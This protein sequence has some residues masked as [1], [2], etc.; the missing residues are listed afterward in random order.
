MPDS[1]RAG[2][3]FMFGTL[4]EFLAVEFGRVGVPPLPVTE[5]AEPTLAPHGTRGPAFPVVVVLGALMGAMIVLWPTGLPLGTVGAVG[6]AI[7]PLF[8]ADA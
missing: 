8:C 3:G 4:F 2:R 7:V 5:P 1:G 6:T